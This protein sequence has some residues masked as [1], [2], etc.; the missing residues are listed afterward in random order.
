MGEKKKSEPR[1]LH[2]VKVELK[3]LYKRGTKN[4]PNDPLPM[5]WRLYSLYLLICV[6][7]L[8]DGK[9]WPP[10]PFG[11][12]PRRDTHNGLHGHQRGNPY[13]KPPEPEDVPMDALDVLIKK[14]GEK[15]DEDT[16]GTNSGGEALRG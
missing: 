11:L 1:G 3:K 2:F 10:D 4:D 7:L 12:I 9:P 5:R 6:E 8:I 14:M 16:S 15:D 13:R